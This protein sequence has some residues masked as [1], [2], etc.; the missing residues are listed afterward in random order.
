[1]SNARK[2]RFC[3]GRSIRASNSPTRRNS[4]PLVSES[5]NGGI[6]M[7]P[8]SD[9]SSATCVWSAIRSD[10]STR[11][12]APPTKESWPALVSMRTLPRTSPGS[13][14]R[15]WETQK[16]CSPL[17][18][19][20]L[21]SSTSVPLSSSG[22]G[23]ARASGS[24]LRMTGKYFASLR[25]SSSGVGRGRRR[26]SISAR[27]RSRRRISPLSR[28]SGDTET[29]ARWTSTCHCSVRVWPSAARPV[30]SNRK[31]KRLQA[32]SQATANW[33]GWMLFR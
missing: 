11:S 14:P 24:R 15:M 4:S 7:R 18:W 23:S 32:R 19:K 22:N 25:W 30:S 26:R 28:G 12:R 5:V 6:S 29:A 17:T 10:S 16:A 33:S 21:I 8:L 27:S 1:M 2:S 13:A 3:T 31:G 20:S 9:A